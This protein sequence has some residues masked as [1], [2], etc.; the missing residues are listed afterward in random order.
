MSTLLIL[1]KKELKSYFL[2]PLGWLI[3]AFA[4]VM[5][6]LSLST[7][8]KGFSDTPVASSLVYVAFHTPHFWFYFLFLFPLITMRLFAEE[9]RSGTLETLLTAPVMTHHMV[10]SKYLAAFTFYCCLWLTSLLHFYLFICLTDIP[11]PFSNGSLIGAYMILFLMGLF[12]TAIGC[13]SSSLTKSQIIAGIVTIAILLFI[14]FL[15]LVTV[16]WGDRFL[17]SDFFNYIASQQHLHYFCEGLID[18]RAVIY[19]LSAT[20]FILFITHHIVDHRRWKN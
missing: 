2:S 13:L 14:Y 10:L 3:I 6:A 7:A 9:E 16:I 11:A 17:A 8:L 5:Q 20:A 18:T 19:Y 4:A 12:F 1:Y 15:G